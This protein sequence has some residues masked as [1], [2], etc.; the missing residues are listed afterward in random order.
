LPSKEGILKILCWFQDKCWKKLCSCSVESGQ[1]KLSSL[2]I[3][4]QNNT[5]K[6]RTTEYISKEIEIN[7][8]KIYQHFCV[9]WSIIHKSKYTDSTEVSINRWMYKDNVTQLHTNTNTGI[10]VSL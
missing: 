4:I 3:P 2:I 6:C 9:Y 1:S 10:P 8:V 7:K 5:G